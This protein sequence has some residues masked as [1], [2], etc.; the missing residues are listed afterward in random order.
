MDA[1]PRALRGARLFCVLRRGA[2]RRV[3]RGAWPRP[4]EL[5]YRLRIMRR[6]LIILAGMTSLS[7]S[8]AQYATLGVERVEGDA[9]ACYQYVSRDATPDAPVGLLVG[10]SVDDG[11][12]HAID[13][14]RTDLAEADLVYGAEGAA[15]GDVV[16]VYLVDRRERWRLPVLYAGRD[17][18]Q[19]GS[20]EEYAV[21][22]V[23]ADFQRLLVAAS[24]D[25]EVHIR[26]EGRRA[27]VDF[28][29]D[30]RRAFLPYVGACL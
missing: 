17:V 16:D 22:G 29:R 25:V 10:F 18:A 15:P 8:H 26:H 4:R 23:D 20:F 6:L 1:E 21:V 3:G 19:D 2:P 24:G 28:P 27:E 5:R 11:V 9:P 14:V 12:T 30:F 7:L 13:V